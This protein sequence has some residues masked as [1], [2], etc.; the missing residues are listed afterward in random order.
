MV[1]HGKNTARGARFPLDFSIYQCLAQMEQ[2]YL[3]IAYPRP[4][5][6]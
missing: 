1:L 3:I 6:D 2:I 4:N 5:I